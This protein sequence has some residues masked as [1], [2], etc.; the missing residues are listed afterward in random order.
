MF[1]ASLFATAALAAE[2]TTI[3]GGPTFEVDYFLKDNEKTV[4]L[5]VKSVPKDGMFLLSFGKPL[6][7]E[8]ADGLL[9]MGKNTDNIEDYYFSKAESKL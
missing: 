1:K 9:M 8:L 7:D 4:R 5:T 3:K 2:L 6:I